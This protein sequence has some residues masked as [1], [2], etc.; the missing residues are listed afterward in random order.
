[1]PDLKKLKKLII[2]LSAIAAFSAS[3]PSLAKHIDKERKEMVSKQQLK[4]DIKNYNNIKEDLEKI[5]K[6]RLK[7]VKN[8]NKII[9]EL[10]DIRKE[11][12][13]SDLSEEGKKELLNRLVSV[14]ID[15][16]VYAVRYRIEIVY[17]LISNGKYDEANKY[18]EFIN[19]GISHLEGMTTD[20]KLTKNLRAEEVIARNTLNKKQK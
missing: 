6:D 12:Y 16:E 5:R 3:N 15:L 19:Q 13:L 1:M 10:S 20:K 17:N 2:S 11:I 8:E 4:E 14:E 9:D 7:Y 18:L